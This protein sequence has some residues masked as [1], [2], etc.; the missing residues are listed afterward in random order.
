V[1]TRCSHCQQDCWVE[2]EHAGEEVV[3]PVCEQAFLAKEPV[4]RFQ[5]VMSIVDVLLT[6]LPALG[7]NQV[8][9]SADVAEPPRKKKRRKRAPKVA[10]GLTCV[11]LLALAGAITALTINGLPELPGDAG[12]STTGEVTA[13]CAPR[14]VRELPMSC[15][16]AIGRFA[17]MR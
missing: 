7:G 13:R 5:A 10:I 1:E 9:K 11:A 15:S 16:T 4:E 17:C 2:D 3:C 14:R 6:E 8:V 12:V